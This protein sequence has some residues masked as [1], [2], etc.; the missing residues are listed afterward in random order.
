MTSQGPMVGDYMSSSFVDGG[1]ALPVFGMSSL[2]ADGRINDAVGL[3]MDTTT[4][5]LTS[6]FSRALEWSRLEKNQ[7]RV[8]V[9]PEPV[10]STRSNQFGKRWS[11]LF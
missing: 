4:Q 11:Y 6:E 7:P 2:L 1:V 8:F 5:N 9:K 3:V 10:L